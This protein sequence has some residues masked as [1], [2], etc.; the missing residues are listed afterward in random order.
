MIARKEIIAI[1]I[2]ALL[3]I[4]LWIALLLWGLAEIIA[5]I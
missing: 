4:P 5:L 2:G 1:V 3:G